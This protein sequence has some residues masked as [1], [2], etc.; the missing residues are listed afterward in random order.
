VRT[1]IDEICDILEVS[2]ISMEVRLEDLPE[3]DSLN[4]L[5][6]IAVLESDYGIQM[7]SSELKRFSN[8]RELNEYVEAEKT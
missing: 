1:F 7:N 6:V 5:S 4:E 2:E 8:L 3:W